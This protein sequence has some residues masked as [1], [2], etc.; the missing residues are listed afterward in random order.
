MEQT[1][2]RQS[3]VD[4]ARGVAIILVLYRH[5]F[6]GLKSSG[7]DVGNYLF[8]EHSNIVFFSFRMPLFFIVSGIFLSASFAK[9]GLRKYIETKAKTILWPYFLWGSLQITLQLIFSKFVNNPPTPYSYLYLLYMPREIEQFWYLYALFNTSVLYVILKYV[10]KLKPW[11]H[12][13]LGLIMFYLTAWC[14]QKNI[15]IGFL[16]GIM[17]Y[18]IFIVLG[19]LIHKIMRKPETIKLFESWKTFLILIIPFAITQGYFLYANLQYPASKYQHVEYFTPFI[20]LPIA[21]TGCAFIISLSFIFQRYHWPDW[22]RV[23]GKHSLYIYV[24]HVLVFASFRIFM[25]R[26]LHIDS[27]LILLLV[28]I[29]SGLVVPVWMYKISK[30]LNIQWV[31]SLEERKKNA[32]DFQVLK[33]LQVPKWKIKNIKNG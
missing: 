14:Y 12:I 5:A 23:L 21:L 15:I 2:K 8:L 3:W 18:Y 6:E 32:K 17:H 4:F 31:F 10:F 20:F 25:M 11:H 7:I 33:N 22:L 24:A 9:R 19:D 28:S 27:V 30:K 1:N 29:I 16:Q 13:A 26:V